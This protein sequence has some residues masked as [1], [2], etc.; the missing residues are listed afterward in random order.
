MQCDDDC[1]SWAAGSR[2]EDTPVNLAIT[3]SVEGFWVLGHLRQTGVQYPGRNGRE[4]T[5]DVEQ[6]DGCRR[7][8]PKQGDLVVRCRRGRSDHRHYRLLPLFRELRRFG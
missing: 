7:V 4:V 2:R 1:A 3:L 6:S 5:V 8:L